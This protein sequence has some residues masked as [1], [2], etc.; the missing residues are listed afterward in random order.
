MLTWYIRSNHELP[1]N[2]DKVPLGKKEVEKLERVGVRIDVDGSR[3][4]DW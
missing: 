1:E 2:F 3:H 4:V